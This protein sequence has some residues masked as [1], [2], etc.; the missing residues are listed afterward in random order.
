MNPDD[1]PESPQD[2]RDRAAADWLAKQQRGFTAAEQDAFFAWLA[3]DPLN[4]EW[5]ATHRRSWQRL[6][7]LVQWC[8]EHSDQTNADLLQ[9][10]LKRARWIRWASGIAAV[11]ALG[12]AGMQWRSRAIRE[13][14][15]EQSTSLIARDRERHTLVDGSRID[16]NRGAAVKIDYNKSERRVDLVANEAHFEVKKDPL[17]P[18]VVVARGVEIVAVGTS[19]NVRIEDGQVEVLVAEGVVRIGRVQ[20]PDTPEPMSAGPPTAS[21]A[22]VFKELQA[23]QTT[24]VSTRDR[25]PV[26]Q[27][28]PSTNEEVARL[29]DWRSLLDFDAVPLGE[30]VAEF[31]R[32]N[33]TQLAIADPRLESLP[34]VA[35]FRSKDPEQFVELLG[36]SLGI[37]ARR[38]AGRI[39]LLGQSE[40]QGPTSTPR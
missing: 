28:H 12:I 33:K 25:E 26:P 17:R 29:L 23:G 22:A 3:E 7:A 8:P 35:S 1:S 39:V 14:P 38:E 6:D 13:A 40:E 18:F 19:F 5:F 16:L 37:K 20:S 34:I 11:I 2:P 30:V 27:I 24:I 10:R 21:L 32:R 36:L 4:G 9:T 31:N 15:P